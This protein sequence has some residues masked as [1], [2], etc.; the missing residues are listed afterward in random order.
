VLVETVA[1]HG[2][3]T[4]YFNAVV[5]LTIITK[6]SCSILLIV[7]HNN[8]IFISVCRFRLKIEIIITHPG[9][10]SYMI[11]EKLGAQVWCGSCCF[12]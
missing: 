6:K 4:S 2:H 7:L 12:V 3:S 1:T 5:P 8:I 11:Y 9:F 10:Y